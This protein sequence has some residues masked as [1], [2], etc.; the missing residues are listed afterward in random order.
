M[1][2]IKILLGLLGLSYVI[3]PYDL[4]PDFFIG[5]G[6]IDDILVLFFLWRLYK[7]YKKKKFAYRGY[8]RGGQ[9]SGQ[10]GARGN[11]TGGDS[12]YSDER[13]KG[14]R[15]SADPYEVLGL[16]QNASIDEI[17]TAYKALA[18]K[19]HPDKVSHL[20]EEFRDLAENRFKEIQAAYQSLV[21]K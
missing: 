14:R 11:A 7:G 15:A 16:R 5:P 6:W 10:N 1:T 13:Q 2:L 3:S 8:T 17:K 9:G 18:H 12:S 4:F 21:K 19:Y 20:G